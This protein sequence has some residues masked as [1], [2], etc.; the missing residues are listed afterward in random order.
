M[1]GGAAAVTARAY[2]GTFHG[3]PDQVREVRAA[4]ASH[5]AGC[6]AADDAVLIVSELATNAVLHSASKGQSFVV[7]V[8]VF[9]TYIWVEAED[10][11][12]AWQCGQPDEYAHGLG[13][14]EALAVWG[15]E[16]T[17]DGNRVVWARVS[18]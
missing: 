17:T 4:V 10:R 2:Q 13:I 9:P 7:R 15:T 11:G 16:E 12:G 8:E 18:L 1:S 6:P 14:V 3:Q 5:L